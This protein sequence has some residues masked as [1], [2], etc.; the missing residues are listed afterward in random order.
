MEL[1]REGMDD[2]YSTMIS[3]GSVSFTWPAERG[4][5][6]RPPPGDGVPG[7]EAAGRERRRGGPR[8]G[9]H[10]RFAVPLGRCSEQPVLSAGLPESTRPLYLRLSPPSSGFGLGFGAESDSCPPVL[11]APA[12]LTFG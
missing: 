11:I 2:V 12:G 10:D 7:E 4:G 1:N 6:S 8:G 5:D 9:C 3:T